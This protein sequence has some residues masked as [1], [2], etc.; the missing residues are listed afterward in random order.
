MRHQGTI[1]EWRDDQG[2]GFVTAHG[3]T[4]RVFAHIKA[5]TDHSR[6]PSVGQI[7]TYEQVTDSTGRF[8]AASIQF[9]A[10]RTTAYQAKTQAQHQP[11]ALS[12][13]VA[14]AF[15]IFLAFAFIA[16]KLPFYIFATYIGLSLLTFLVYALDKSAAESRRWRTSEDKLHILAVLGGWPGA[17]LA[18]NWLRH[19]SKKESFQAAFWVTVIINCCALG[20]ILTKGDNFISKALQNL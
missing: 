20:Y 16:L 9:P 5:F 8:R 6:R 15:F 3:G 10:K 18:Q 14:F 1:T 12:T 2:F 17:L 19:K 13:T 4:Q 11:S 7:V